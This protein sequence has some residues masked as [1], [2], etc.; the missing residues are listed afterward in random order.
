M[1]KYDELIKKTY[2]DPSGYGSVQETYKDVRK[3]DSAI[4]LS[5]VKGLV[6]TQ[7]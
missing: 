7:C 3:L 5:D 1:T 2:Y 6:R 4:K